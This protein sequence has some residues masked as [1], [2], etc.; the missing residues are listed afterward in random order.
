MC[1]FQRLLVIDLC[2]HQVLETHR[3][4]QEGNALLHHGRVVLVDRFVEGKTVLEARAPSSRYE[5]AQLQIGV[6][7]LIEQ[8]T[9]LVYNLKPD[10]F[11][12]LGAQSHV[13]VSFDQPTYTAD[14]TAV[15]TLRLLEAIR[16]FQDAVGYQIRFYQ[17]ST[18]E[19]YGLVQE[20]PQKETTPFYPRS[21]YAVA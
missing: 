18:S 4:D 8:I 15:G 10:E 20:I 14:V 11:Y 17:A 5:H 13:R 9:N 21:P 16:D 7:F 3:V 12:H 2:A 19:L 6:A 1:A